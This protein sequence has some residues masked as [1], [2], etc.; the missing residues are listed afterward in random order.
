MNGFSLRRTAMVGMIAMSASL[1]LGCGGIKT[2]TVTGKLEFKGQP[3]T[4]GRVV[5]ICEGGDHPV[6]NG[7]VRNGQFKVEKVPYG[8]VKVTAMS[9]VTKRNK[10]PNMPKDVI[11]PGMAPTAEPGTEAKAEPLAEGA[12]VV[13]PTKFGAPETSGMSFEMDT[14]EKTVNFDLKP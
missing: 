9:Y 4:N 11:E 10:V 13:L 5:L 3:I 2:G 14:S 6:L 12:G 1:S 8:P 7:E